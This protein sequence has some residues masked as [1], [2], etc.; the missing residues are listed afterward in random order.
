VDGCALRLVVCVVVAASCAVHHGAAIACAIPELSPDDCVEDL[1]V[2]ISS[3]RSDQRS[4]A[5]EG[6][7]S[8]GAAAV[9]S[10]IRATT[11]NNALLR[12]EAVNLLGTLGDLRATDA[13]LLLAM[14]DLDVHV[15]WRSNWAITNLN[16][17]TVI[18]R[19]IEGLAEGKDPAIAWN[20]AVTLS[21]FG[22]CDAVP[23]LHAGITASDWRQWEA[24][25]ALGRV[26]ID[27]TVLLLIP[28]LEEGPENV[29]KEAALSLGRIGGGEALAALLAALDGDPAAEVRW[30]AAMMIGS[31]GDQSA[32]PRLLGAQSRE[33]DAFVIE[34]IDGA[35]E[36][37][38]RDSNSS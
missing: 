20:C 24:V 17:G 37:L 32:L 26:W 34:H 15:R 33:T 6:L 19:L 16:D 29:R 35:I 12:W 5:R 36:R 4:E 28:V 14:S 2:Q 27:E 10:L 22:I 8:L 11:S 9:P 1:V 30:R 38:S 18:P 13:V 3:S 21:L 31:M 7:L 23:V 25:N